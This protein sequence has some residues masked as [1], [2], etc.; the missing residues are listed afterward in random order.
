[1]TD[2]TKHGWSAAQV[3]AFAKRFAGSD[4]AR[5]WPFFVPEVREALVRSFVLDIALGVDRDGRDPVPAT[6]VQ[7]LANDVIATLAARH[8]MPLTGIAP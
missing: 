8:K 3:T 2:E 1:M 6:A 7:G 4:A 5:A